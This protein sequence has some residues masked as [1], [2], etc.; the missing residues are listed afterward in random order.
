MTGRDDELARLRAENA[1]LIALLEAHG[2]VWRDA[3]PSA[4][5]HCCQAMIAICLPLISTNRTG[6]M[7][8]EPSFNLAV[9]WVFRSRWKFRAPAMVP[10]PGSSFPAVSLPAMPAGWE[11][12]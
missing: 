1:R 5:I 8:P 7:M 9:S 6:V 10:M 11:R 3:I 12:L 4:F 2:I